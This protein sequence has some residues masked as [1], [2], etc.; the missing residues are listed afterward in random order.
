MFNMS[1][2]LFISGYRVDLLDK[3]GVAKKIN[4]EINTFNK[5]GFQVDFLE[6][7]SGNVF[8]NI[9]GDR[10]FICTESKSFYQTMDYVYKYFLQNIG[11]LKHYDMIYL[12]YEHFSFSMTRFFKNI[13]RIN[14][15]IKIV[16][17]LPTYMKK[18]NQGSSLK[19]KILFNVKR[20]LNNHTEKHIDYLATF[21]SHEKLF[22]MP[23]IQI[24]NFVNIDKINVREP[25]EN[26]VLDL[27]ALAQITPAHGF[28]RVIKGLRQYYDQKEVTKR[29]FLHIV[30]DGVEKGLLERLVHDLDL[31]QYVKFYG[32]LGGDDLDAIF[33]LSDVGIG[34]LAIFR[35]GSFKCSELKVREY[36]ARGLPFIYSAD[37]PQIK[38]QKFARKVAFDETLIDI[39]TVVEFYNEI[40][41][42][43]DLLVEMREFA[44]KEFT[45]EHQLRKIVNTIYKK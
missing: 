40:N 27:L 18:P 22:N 11:A 19:T 26:D 4:L 45:C 1:S 5:I 12:R 39:N 13:K 24:E 6:F 37:E 30:G 9:D 31:N 23:T 35:K 15:R 41:K 28:D 42:N 29:V 25:I 44:E 7:D 32:A 38:G 8:L 16:G 36:T 34:S 21:S 17:E 14:S 43:S 20:F 10:K 2:I 33:N 3:N